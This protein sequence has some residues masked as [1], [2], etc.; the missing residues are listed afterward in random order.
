MLK[1]PLLNNAST[2]IEGLKSSID[3]SAFVQGI[4][5]VALFWAGMFA[6]IFLQAG[7]VKEAMQSQLAVRTVMIDGGMPFAAKPKEVEA[8]PAV[9]VTADTPEIVGKD[10]RIS[11]PREIAADKMPVI[12]EG[13]RSSPI[14]GLS[15]N[16]PGG[17]LPQKR[18]HDA[19]TPFDA[20]KRPY[21]FADKTPLV[22]LLVQDFGLSQS[23]SQEALE[24]LPPEISVL[25]S[26]YSDNIQEIATSARNHGHETWLETP[27]ENRQFEF[28]DPGPT[29]IMSRH[30]L[31]E[32]QEIM[33]KLMTQ[34]HGYAG[35]AGYVDNSF[36]NFAATMMDALMEKVFER[37]IGYIDLNPAA[38]PLMPRLSFNAGSAYA[39]VDTRANDLATLE[40]LEEKARSN[41]F[42]LGA[43]QL[44]PY[45]LKVIE[46]WVQSLKDKNI[47]LV[48]ASAIADAPTRLMGKTPDTNNAEGGNET[49]TENHSDTGETLDAPLD[50]DVPAEENAHH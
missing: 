6:Y 27:M 43:I 20:Y 48:P 7:T 40:E 25:V 22:A 19:L 11:P 38:P 30:G 9:P 3:A 23:L 37:G 13:L 42:A 16:T 45:N 1:I 29:I 46:D 8:V 33:D 39:R 26:P 44:T 41:R 12:L 18:K 21:S 28:A 10:S 50:P 32:N 2:N 5:L 36:N 31:K 24:K 17:L 35:I 49:V 47:T 34:F 15:Q 4:A 14:E